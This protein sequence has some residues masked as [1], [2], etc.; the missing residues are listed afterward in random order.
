MKSAAAAARMDR[1]QIAHATIYLYLILEAARSAGMSE[2]TFQTVSRLGRDFG[3]LLRM[4][5]NINRVI[6]WR[7]G[8]IISEDGFNSYESRSRF[9][10]VAKALL[11]VKQRRRMATLREI[12]LENLPPDPAARIAFLRAAAANLGTATVPI[13][14]EEL[15]STRISDSVGAWKSRLQ[16]WALT[17]ADASVFHAAHERASSRRR[18]V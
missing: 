7:R 6:V 17:H 5:T 10:Q 9:W 1:S 3:L 8:V 18:G 13:E 16:R 4:L 12:L 2:V 11:P 14:E 15:I